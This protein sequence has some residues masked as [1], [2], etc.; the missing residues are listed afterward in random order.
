MGSDDGNSRITSKLVNNGDATGSDDFW[1]NDTAIG[2]L[3]VLETLH[4]SCGT[5]SRGFMID[6]TRFV[7]DRP[8]TKAFIVGRRYIVTRS[9]EK[10]DANAIHNTRRVLGID[11]PIIGTIVELPLNVAQLLACDVHL[12]AAACKIYLCFLLCKQSRPHCS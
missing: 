9:A 11:P 4:R 6:N 1:A 7:S 8:E 2:N 10:R 12:T 3:S 5:E